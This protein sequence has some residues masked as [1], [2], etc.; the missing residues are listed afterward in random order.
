MAV[1]YRQDQLETITRIQA[2]SA[3]I[4]D[5]LAD[6]RQIIQEAIDKGFAPGTAVTGVTDALLQTGVNG[7]SPPFPDLSAAD[8]TA[9]V[10][11]INAIDAA[12]AASTRQHFKSLARMR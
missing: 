2:A 9:A 12:L 10:A 7:G 11:A 1:E 3:V 4:L 6:A 8:I 5:T